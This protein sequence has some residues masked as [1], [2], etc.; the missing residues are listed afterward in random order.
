MSSFAHQYF[1]NPVVTKLIADN[2]ASPNLVSLTG[3]TTSANGQRIARWKPPIKARVPFL[4]V[5]IDATFPVLF[6]ALTAYKKS[7]VEFEVASSAEL[8]GIKITDRIEDL[9]KAAGNT[10]LAYFNVSDDNV[11]NKQ[12]RYMRTELSEYDEDTDVWLASVWAEFHWIDVP[13]AS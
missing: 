8:D 6:D 13:C 5:R 9:L 3:H 1:L 4:G 10:D 11:N 2:A 7:I 12:T